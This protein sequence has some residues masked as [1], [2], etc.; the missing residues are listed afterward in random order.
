MSIFSKLSKKESVLMKTIL[1]WFGHEAT[2]NDMT[3]YN[4]AAKQAYMLNVYAKTCI[5]KVASSVAGLPYVT[6]VETRDGVEEVKNSPYLRLMSRPNEYTSGEKFIES[7][8]SYY[9]LS[10]NVYI[11]KVTVAGKPR[12]LWLHKPDTIEKKYTNDPKNPIQG[13]CYMYTQSSNRMIEPQNMLHIHTFDPLDRHLGLGLGI[14]PL[15][16]VGHSVDQNNTG[17]TWNLSLLQNSANPSGALKTEQRLTEEQRDILQT[18]VQKKYGNPMSAG[19]PMI[20]EGDLEWIQMGMSPKDMEWLEGTKMSAKEIAI[21]LGVPPELIGDSVNKTYSNYKEAR[22][23][24]YMETV[25]PL[26][27]MICGELNNFLSAS[28][29]DMKLMIDKDRIDALQ[30]DRADLFKRMNYSAFLTIN[31]K[32][33]ATGYETIG[34][35]GDV[36]LVPMAMI[37]IGETG[38]ENEEETEDGEGE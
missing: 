23:A 26:A 31:E 29:N 27:K 24:F 8:V 5:E 38:I 4:V 22:K 17:K 34:K 9:F 2:S 13:Y 10:G 33:I 19:K 12:E 1:T 3:N 18:Q 32:R 14:S 30:E 28:F 25:L 7:L 36:V 11:E 16:A 21:G 6:Q 15:T 20:L 37:P 35:E